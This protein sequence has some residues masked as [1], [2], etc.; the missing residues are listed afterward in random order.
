MTND[1][2]IVVQFSE[3]MST[4]SIFNELVKIQSWPTVGLV[5]ALVIIVG[6]C[7]RFWKKFPNEAIPTVVILVGAVGMILISDGKPDDIPSRVWNTKNFIIGLIIGFIAWMAHNLVISKIEDFLSTKFAVVNKALGPKD[8]PPP[9][10]DPPA[11]N[12][13]DRDKT[14]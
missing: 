6:Y 11:V 3:T 9:P 2:T 13:L 5:F 8:P 7:L 10:I 4:D 14:P 1:D 12:P